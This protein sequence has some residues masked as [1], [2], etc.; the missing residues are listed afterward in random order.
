MTATIPE[1]F[2]NKLFVP[3]NLID[4]NRFNCQSCNKVISKNTIITSGCI[5]YAFCFLCSNKIINQNTLGCEFCWE[6]IND[7][8]KRGDEDG[9]K[10]SL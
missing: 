6:H 7:I 10:Y 3:S 8:N 4:K 9:A 1:Q 2:K 5:G